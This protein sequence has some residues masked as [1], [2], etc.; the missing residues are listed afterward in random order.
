[1]VGL[2]GLLKREDRSH[3]ALRDRVGEIF[4]EL[5]VPVYRYLLAMLEPAEA[6]DATQEAFLRLFTQVQDR[7]PIDNV[8]SWVFQTAHNLAIDRLRAGR[9]E[10]RWDERAWTR[11]EEELIESSPDAQHVFLEKE[12]RSRVR[13]A[14][15]RLSPQERRSMELRAEGL[16][17]REIAEV[18]GV[19]IS[20]V[21]NY[22]ARGIQKVLRTTD[23]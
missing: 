13:E 12:R 19:R 18:L 11:I 22:L 10:E 4:L 16:R 3:T 5:R 21:Q 9:R 8:R 1:M 6:E 20:S 2:G 15:A 23:V 14:V 7:R 17:Y